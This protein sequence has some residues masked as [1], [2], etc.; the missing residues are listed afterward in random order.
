[1]W[2][3]KKI[4]NNCALARDTSGQD[5]VVFGRGIGFKH[6]PY[7]LTDL[8]MI[9][10][11]FY[12]VRSSAVA[13]LKDIPED[14]VF[15]ASDVIEHARDV[16]G[17]DL[18]PNAPVTLADH[19]NFAINRAREGVALQTPLAFDVR[20]LYPKE[21]A[22]GRH[23]VTI[24]KSRMGVELPE[25]EC[26]SIALHII[27]AESERS[28]LDV[29]KAAAETVDAVTRMIEEVL[30]AQLDTDSFQFSRFV[31]HLSF[32]VGR[33]LA[34]ERHEDKMA[35]MLDVMKAAYPDASCITKRVMDFFA[36][37]GWSCDQSEE[38]YL[39]IHIQRL[40]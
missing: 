33:M 31:M 29:T 15:L 4:N 28:D 24:V 22:I 38:L 27:D 10:R 13:A 5:V 7:E 25:S 14:I 9:D 23:A 11:T 30:G 18:N 21:F 3:V 32:L 40:L 19:I 17:V 6:I 35:E 8:S 36:Q 20:H 26:A 16:L 12:G 1:M 34:G 37:R 2:I 39:L